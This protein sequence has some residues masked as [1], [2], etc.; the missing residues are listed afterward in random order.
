MI[1]FFLQITMS[2]IYYWAD[3]DNYT[4]ANNFTIKLIC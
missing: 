4:I 3:L 1:L 2:Q